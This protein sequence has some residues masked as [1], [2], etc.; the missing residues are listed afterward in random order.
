VITDVKDGGKKTTGIRKREGA[1]RIVTKRSRRANAKPK[2]DESELKGKTSA[3]SY[4][5]NERDPK[6]SGGSGSC[7]G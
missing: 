7:E 6:S 2:G 1:S 4:T 3:T 5:D